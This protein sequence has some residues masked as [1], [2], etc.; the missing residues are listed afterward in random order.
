MPRNSPSPSGSL[1]GL[2]VLDRV[3]A[4][5]PDG[6]R[7]FDNLTLA[8]GRER[9]GLV[10][11]NGVGKSTLLRLL[12]GE[13]RA[14]AGVIGRTGSAGFLSQRYEPATDETVADTLGVGAGLAVI[15]R[16]L[17][18][19]GSAE[20]LAEADWSRE[21]RIVE[22]LA[23]TGLRDLALNGGL[24]R[25]TASL[26][27]GEQ[28]RLRLADLLIRAPDLILLDEPTNHLDAEAR[29]I[30]AGVLDRWKGG[31]V[32]VSHDRDLLRRMDRIVELSSLGAA[33]YGG[34]YDRYLALRTAERAAAERDL[35][36]AERSLDRAEREAQRTVERQARRDRAGRAFAA[37]GSEPKI[38]L[39]AQAERAENT[40]ARDGRMAEKRIGAA[41]AELEAAE[42]RVERVRSLRIALPPTGLAAGA[43]VLTMQGVV[44]R[45][46]EGRR[47]LG[48]L[49][50][51]ITGPHRLG[52]TGK[53]GAGKS[54][55]LKLAVGA[56][57][58][59]AGL[60]SRPVAA[61]Y[62]DQ[63]VSLLRPE[64]TLTQAFRRLNPGASDNAA[65]AALA[66]FLFRNT[67]GDKRVDQLSGGE[68]L[69]AGLACATGGDQPAR[70]LVLDEPTN[71]LDLDALEAVEAALAVYDGAL[72]VVSHD[73]GFLD[74]LRLD[75]RLEL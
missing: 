15:S 24:G 53:N 48:P 1:S 27:G 3:S 5:T 68:R 36:S 12:A 49:D 10:G 6:F 56:L 46:P 42:R 23:E 33:V 19:E 13:Q 9:T 34:N 11:R 57:E 35:A 29:G 47:I 70:F 73:A 14:S 59:C 28:T 37:R 20:D 2:A 72:M 38:L 18:G 75:E 40:G 41:S 74:A 63:E 7:L 16:V 51:S 69:R 32:V 60:V 43:S 50:L 54:T 52:V 44:W 45:T 39:G 65:R 26:S 30:V 61:A 66:R 17:A 71:H 22:A 25:G 64:E 58:P 31:A 67:A 21:R 4:D 8:F 62:L 55:L